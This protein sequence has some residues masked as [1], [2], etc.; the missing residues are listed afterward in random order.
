MGFAVG[1]AVGPYKIV[2]YVGQG[3]MATIFKAYQATLDRYVALKVIHPAL[4]EDPSFTTRLKREAAIIANLNHPN[5]VTVYD[6]G[7]FEGIPFLVLRFIEG[8]TLKAVLQDQRLETS[9]ILEIIRPVAEALTYAHTRG[10]LHRDVKP[11]NILIDPEGHVYLTD[12]GLARLLRTGESTLSRDM[13]IG[14]PQYISPEQ[15]KGE[16]ADV[17]SDIYAL[18]IVLF[19]MFTGRVPFS[20]ETPYATIIAQINDPLPPPRS[21]NPTIPPAVEQVLLKALAKNPG[22]RYSSVR[23]M[24]RALQNAVRGPRLVTAIGDR[25]RRAPLIESSPARV[26][27]AAATLRGNLQRRKTLIAAGV[28]LLALLVFLFCIASIGGLAL[29]TLLFGGATPTRAALVAPTSIGSPIATITLMPAATP[30]F[31]PL[32]QSTPTRPAATPAP[33][34]ATPLAATPL[35]ATPT[36][37]PPAADVPRGRIAYSVVTG[38]LAEQHSIWLANADGSGAHQ[39]VEMA[40]WP[41]VSPDGKQ[42]AYYRMKDAGIYVSNIDGTSPRKALGFSDTCCVQWSP[43]STR[44]VYYRGN[45]K[46]GGAIFTANADGANITEIV[47][48]FNPAWSPDGNR[49]AYAGCQPNTNQCGLF[50]YDLKTKTSAMITRDAGG[51]PQWSPRGDKIVYQASDGKAP[52]NVFT[53]N[54]DGSGVK[55]LT[56]GKTTT[57]SRSGRAM[58]ISS[59]GARIRMARA[60]EFS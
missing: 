56:F 24:I 29:Q 48:G 31:T 42:I 54:P 23:E 25:A 11:S 3:G 33:L 30:S 55:Q 47:Q 18:G 37:Q 50:V 46:F 60:G 16:N 40:M 39:I 59:S 17:R 7:E 27:T 21:F 52:A 19:E 1:E 6:F 49:I 22:E 38:D 9:Q 34:V 5:I 57:D 12:F 44:L 15:A 43:D 36:R 58:A 4:K 26:Q 20:G 35:A 10:V 53:I 51:S 45:L 28:A 13:L 32:A 14:S 41:S 8:K 2:E